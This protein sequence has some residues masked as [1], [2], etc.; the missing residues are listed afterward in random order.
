[1]CQSAAYDV[2]GQPGREG[3]TRDAG[4]CKNLDRE[5][6]P[7]QSDSGYDREQ[8]QSQGV[9]KNN[10][11]YKKLCACIT[12]YSDLLYSLI[13]EQPISAA[14]LAPIVGCSKP[15]VLK[16][17]NRLI[18]FKIVKRTSFENHVLYCINGAFN[19]LIYEIFDL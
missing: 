2:G 18:K 3:Y 11:E 19:S 4:G 13:S 8:V 16:D 5:A 9:A 10:H 1:M 6:H 15:T 12:H 7:T 17:L 14:E